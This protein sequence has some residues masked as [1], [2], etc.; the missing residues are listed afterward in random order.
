MAA[1]FEGSGVL[2]QNSGGHD[3]FNVQSSCT[4][5]HVQTYLDTGKVPEQGTLCE[6]DKKPLVDAV[7]KRDVIGFGLGAW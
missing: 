7:V 1:F 4:I 5:Q 2:V 6:T 3:A